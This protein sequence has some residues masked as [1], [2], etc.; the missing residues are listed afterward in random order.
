[1]TL[2]S[3]VAQYQRTAPVHT[4]KLT[5]NSPPL[6]SS[7]LPPS[8]HHR[9]PLLQCQLRV[10]HVDHVVGDLIKVPQRLD[11]EPHHTALL[12]EGAN[13]AQHSYKYAQPV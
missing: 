3:N 12:T 10:Q 7:P 6:P 8:P 11:Q 2:S 9:C 13:V 4:H 1:M 5:P